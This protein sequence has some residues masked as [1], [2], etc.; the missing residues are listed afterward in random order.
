MTKWELFITLKT[1]PLLSMGLKLW[2]V[3]LFI[4]ISRHWFIVFLLIATAL[5][6]KFSLIFQSPRFAD[7]NILVLFGF[8]GSRA[9][10]RVKFLSST[11][12]AISIK[13]PSPYGFRRRNSAHISGSSPFINVFSITSSEIPFK[14]VARISNSRRYAATVPCHRTARNCS[15]RLPSWVG[16]KRSNNRLFKF[17]QLPNASLESVHWYQESASA[18]KL[19]AARLI[20]PLPWVRTLQSIDRLGRSNRPGFLP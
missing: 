10:L 17:S 16:W 11:R 4:R 7:D 3:S 13:W 9:A 5:V 8:F 20:S 14:G 12:W 6:W 15:Q 1:E 2:F 18:S 19:I